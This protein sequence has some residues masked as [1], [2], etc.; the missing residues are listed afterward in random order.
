M[1]FYVTLS[2][3]RPEPIIIVRHDGDETY[4]AHLP[5]QRKYE[6]AQIRT[7]LAAV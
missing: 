2:D 6:K 3:R 7:H 1:L 4:I 5:I